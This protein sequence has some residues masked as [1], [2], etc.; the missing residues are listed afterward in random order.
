[1]ISLLRRI[2]QKL[3]A[4]GSVTKYLLYAIG[5]ILLVVIGILIALQVNNW[6]EE[7]KS[8]AEEQLLLVNL[9]TDFQTR[10]DE[11]NE[12]TV[13]RSKSLETIHALTEYIDAPTIPKNTA[14]LDT[15]MAN[16][17]NLLLF[18]DQFKVL[19]VLFNT[20]RIDQVNNRELKMLLLNWV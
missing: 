11:L 3:I 15:M 1:M 18:N 6:N 16:M 14:V 7:N 19:D 5:E 13:V 12:L 2:R 4:S 17:N 10:L 20:G 9:R 8:S